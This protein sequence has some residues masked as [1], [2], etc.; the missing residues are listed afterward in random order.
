MNGKAKLHY[1]DLIFG[2]DK[3]QPQTTMVVYELLTSYLPG[4]KR[5]VEIGVFE[6]LTTRMLAER[7][8]SD[9]LEYEV[10]PFFTGR[11]GICSGERLARSY[12]PHHL[13]NGKIRLFSKLSTDVGDDVQI[14]V[15][16]MFI[17]GDHS[18]E[19]VTNDWAFWTERLKRGA[20]VAMHDT[21]LT[22]D[23]PPCYTLESIQ[24]YRNDISHDWLF[25]LIAQQDS[26]SVLQKRKPL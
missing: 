8:D 3:T 19:S 14:P 21:L 24:Y 16:L 20:V 23:K 9:A 4:A 5:I 18:L 2:I 26:M 17:E 6:G 15:D 7:S 22:P 12:N 11:L 10:D 1:A 25:E 13:A